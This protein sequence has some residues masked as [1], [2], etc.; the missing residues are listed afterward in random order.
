MLV[1]YAKSKSLIKFFNKKN[2][3]FCKKLKELYKIITKIDFNI[4]I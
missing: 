3:C 2:E 4:N 1:I